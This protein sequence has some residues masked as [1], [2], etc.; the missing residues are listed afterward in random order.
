MGPLVTWSEGA[1][2]V[3]AYRSG[4]VVAEVGWD[5]ELG[6]FLARVYDLDVRGRERCRWSRGD[7]C[8]GDVPDAGALLAAIGE[9]GGGDVP[10]EAWSEAV[11]ALPRALQGLVG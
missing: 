1:V 5:D 9:Y 8:V 6:S 7:E 4:S 11:S 10:A 3:D 2:F